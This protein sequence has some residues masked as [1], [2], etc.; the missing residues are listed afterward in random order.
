M[1]QQPPMNKTQL[2]LKSNAIASPP[3]DHILWATTFRY[4]ARSKAND[5]NGFFVSLRTGSGR[6]KT[7][8]CSVSQ[9]LPTPPLPSSQSA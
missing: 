7:A 6:T 3:R 2:L 9:C 5:G 4:R 1:Q 8:A